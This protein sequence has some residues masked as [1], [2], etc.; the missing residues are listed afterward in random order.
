MWRTLDVQTKALVYI[1]GGF[2]APFVMLGV[3]VIWESF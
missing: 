3:A 2:V 1:L